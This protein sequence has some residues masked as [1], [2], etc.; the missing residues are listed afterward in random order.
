MVVARHRLEII[1]HGR[2]VSRRRVIEIG[3][4]HDLGALGVFLQGLKIEDEFVEWLLQVQA[5]AS[6]VGRRGIAIPGIDVVT[7]DAAE[8]TGVAA[9]NEVLRLLYL[10]LQILQRV[11]VGLLQIIRALNSSVSGSARTG[12]TVGIG[13]STGCGGAGIG[14]TSFGR[15]RSAIRLPRLA[16]ILALRRTLVLPLTLSL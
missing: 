16:V 9:V 6:D 8:R 4:F 3:R 1:G 14:P 10:I 5:I 2:T 15:R 11:V 13:P 12:H 7:N